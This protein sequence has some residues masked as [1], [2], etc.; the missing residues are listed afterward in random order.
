M[1]KGI[2]TDICHIERIKKLAP[3]A[4][5]RILTPSEAEYCG[6]YTSPHERIAGRF[7]AKEAILK[8]L[9]TGW[10]GGLGWGQMEILPDTSG[11]PLVT[12]TGAAHAKLR[13]LGATR[14]LVSISHQAEYAVAFAIIE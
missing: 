4:V 6:R 3:E 10:S 1:V 12:L 11:A 14:C 5:A 13:E 9:G 7:A 2:G 8:A